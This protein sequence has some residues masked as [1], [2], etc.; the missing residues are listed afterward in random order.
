M[1]PK[2][3]YHM[4]DN[5]DQLTFNFMSAMALKHKFPTTRYQGSK[6][7]WADWIYESVKGLTFDSVLDVFGGTGAV[8]YRFKQA[9]KQVTYN[10]N[11]KFNAVIGRA[12]IENNSVIL[13][14][15]TVDH[16]LLADPVFEYR[17]TISEIFAGI[18]FTDAENQWLDRVVQNINQ[19]LADPYQQALALFAVYQACLVKRPYNLFHRKN[20][21]VR[22]AE[23]E[24]SFGNKTTWDKPFEKHFKRFVGEANSA[25]FD[26]GRLNKSLNLDAFEL[27]AGYDLVYIDPPYLNSRGI[28]VD[29]QH[30]YHFLEGLT[31]Y[32][33]WDKRID[34]GSKHRRLLPTPSIWSDKTQ[35]HAAF[36][37]LF[38]HFAGSILVVS[39]RS[40]GIPTREELVNMLKRH[41]RIVVQA[42]LPQ[43][44]ALS[45]NSSTHELLL[46][47]R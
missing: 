5:T 21:Y 26:N 45:K 22:E 43:Q 40:D 15:E 1:R 16:L 12:L 38:E 35:I 6:R 33:D 41:K 23:V 31:D 4:S 32:S 10:D 37:R 19:Q 30:F 47:G 29:Y 36:E 24:R 3:K 11:L 8:A 9:G 34:F 42:A 39:Y 2:H 46:I 44:Y 7:K 27:P 28:G 14:S 17:S 20:L 18:Y 13:D 25:V